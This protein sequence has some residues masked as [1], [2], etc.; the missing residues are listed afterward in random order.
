MA[1]TVNAMDEMSIRD[2]SGILN[3]GSISYLAQAGN[4]YGIGTYG[5]S[6]AGVERTLQSS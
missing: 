2:H 4:S 5:A 1:A 3:P 6:S